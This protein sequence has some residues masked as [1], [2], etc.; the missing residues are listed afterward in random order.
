METGLVY[1]LELLVGLFTALAAWYTV[2]EKTIQW[3]TLHWWLMLMTVPLLVMAHCYNNSDWRSIVS[4]P[5]IVVLALVANSIFWTLHFTINRLFRSVAS[6]TQSAIVKKASSTPPLNDKRLQESSTLTRLGIRMTILAL[7]SFTITF[8]L[9]VVL[10]GIRHY[11]QHKMD[12]DEQRLVVVVAKTIRVNP[13]TLLVL[14]S[15][16]FLG[17]VALSAASTA[18][19]QSLPPEEETGHHINKNTNLSRGSIAFSFMVLLTPWSGLEIAYYFPALLPILFIRAAPFDKSAGI[20]DDQRRS[21]LAFVVW[22]LVLLPVFSAGEFYLVAVRGSL[23]RGTGSSA[24]AQVLP[25]T[26]PVT[27]R[28]FLAHRAISMASVGTTTEQRQTNRVVMETAFQVLRVVV[29]LSWGKVIFKMG[30]GSHPVFGHHHCSLLSA[31]SIVDIV[32]ELARLAS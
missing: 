26:I 4:L 32:N 24:A 10:N 9:Y 29:I 19:Q 3:R 18:C 1:N 16:L 30:V 6:S 27:M 12:V 17:A 8:I 31:F 11:N 22:V 20:V 23:Y 28:L 13:L 15:K 14:S 21:P 2:L 5:S 7:A 25:W